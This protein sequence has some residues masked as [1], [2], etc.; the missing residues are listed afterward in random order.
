MVVRFCYHSY[1]YRPNWTPL[2]PITIT[3]GRMFPVMLLDDFVAIFHLHGELIRFLV[4]GHL[5]SSFCWRACLGTLCL[6]CYLYVSMFDVGGQRD[7]RRKWIQCF[8]GE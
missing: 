1:D 7:E 2:T 5:S 6:I 3:Y 8:N 4:P